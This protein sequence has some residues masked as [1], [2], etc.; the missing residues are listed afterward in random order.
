MTP[1]TS[2]QYLKGVGEK[3][4]ALYHK[5][6]VATALDLLYHFPRGYVDLSSPF[7]IREAP[8]LEPCAVRAVLR[9]KSGEQVIRKGLSIFKL[10]AQDETGELEVT[11]FNSK[12]TVQQLEIGREYIFYGKVSGSLLRREMSSPDIYPTGGDTLIVPIYPQTAGL[13]G[14]VIQRNVR[15]ALLGLGGLAD[16]IPPSIRGRDGLPGLSAALRDIHFPPSLERA[17]AAR[18]RFVFEEL[19]TL[20]CAL[21]TSRGAHRK[22][23]IRPIPTA[24]LVPFY[25]ALPFSPTNAQ[26]RC[27]ADAAADMA[28]DVSMN[29]IIQGDVGSGKTLV[30]LACVYLAAKGGRQSAVMVPTSILA[31]QHYAT[32]SGMLRPFGLRVELLTGNVTAAKRRKI[33]DALAAGEIDLLIGT[34]ALLSDGVEFACLGLVV[35]DEQHR[36]GVAQR[37]KLS[38][39]SESAHVLVMSATPIPR[40]L[41]LIIY[42]DLSLSVLDEKPPGRQAVETLL[43]DGAKR[44]RA[45]GFLR[46]ALDD[47]RQ[48]YIVCPLIE[49]GELNPDLLPATEYARALGEGELRGYRVGL[50]HGRMKTKEKDDVMR[51]FKAGEIQALV[52]TTVVEVGVDVANATIIMIEN[53]ERFGLSQLHQLRGR[54]GRAE[55]KSWCI[56]VT[57]SRDNDTLRRLRAIKDQ[58]D[59]F[60]I[61]EEDLSIRGPGDFFGF[62]QHGLPTLKVADLADDVTL[63]QCAQREAGALLAI[64]PALDLPEHQPL[65][66]R[67]KSMLHSVGERP[68]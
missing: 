47:G 6:G 54:V 14:R 65:A 46:K 11:I 7:C 9:R 43:I 28:L 44:A 26:R 13:T 35:T 42:G 38:Q 39:K 63:M 1:D 22:V 45:M 18:R 25:A 31:E 53:A 64:D 60:K 8:I 41:A 33:F 5:L 4:A 21:E 57:D 2:I 40:T 61:A 16:P 17:K 62:R 52:S 55:H 12:Y 37:V 49:Q 58:S 27:I 51:R 10:L 48:A 68:N 3:R 15:Q 24:D 30:A 66:R 29:R 67:V 56:L 34:H 32:M 23:K 59:G 36:F 19:L 20:S 50:L